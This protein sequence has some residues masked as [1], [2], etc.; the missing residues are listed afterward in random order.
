MPENLELHQF[1]DGFRHSETRNRWLSRIKSK[2]NC[3]YLGII[4]ATLSS[5]FF[6]L[7]SVIVKGLVDINPMELASFRFV[8]VLLPAIPIVIY[9]KQPVFPEGKRVILLLRCFMGTTGLMLSF[10]AFRHMPLADA[11]VII[12]STPVFVAIF[13]RVFLKEH[14]SLFNILTIILTLVGVVLITR[15]PFVFGQQATT[16]VNLERL[17]G[18]HYDIWGPVAAISSTLFG[19]NV[20]ILLRALKGLHFSVI[21]TN[22]GAFAL[23]YTIIVCG[24]IGAICWPACGRDRWL[25]VVLGIFSFLGQILLT[26]SL[27]VE[28]AG[29]VA[30]ARCADI[31]FAFIWQTM[32]FGETPTG[33]SLVG[34]M[35][36]VSSVILTALK[37]WALSL[38]R[39]STARKRLRYLLLD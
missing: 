9:T 17:D 18:K 34:A 33:Y 3:P 2:L 38:P 28:Q 37:K 23:I 20:Y 6:S 31:V 5:L 11:S 8:G 12:F 27:Q 26:L 22:F 39:E 16:D 35:L 32:F 25:V 36:V 7:C 10:Y 29:P 15:P 13:A 24:T 19:A 14:C 30:I 4:L 21:M 1:V